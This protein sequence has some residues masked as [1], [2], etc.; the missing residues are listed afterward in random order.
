MQTWTKKHEPRKSGDVEGQ[1]DGVKYLKDF[2]EHYKKHKKRS[3]ILYGPVGCG[4]TVSVY[5]VA[6]ELGLEIIEVNASDF[7][8]E[9]GV[10]STVGSASRQMSLFSKG[11]II[12]VDEIDGLSGTED[13]GGINALAALIEKSAFPIICT[14][15]DPFDKKFANLRKSSEMMQFMPLDYNSIFNILAKICREEK[16]S[17]KDDDLKSLA[18]RIGGDARA[19]VN[20][21]QMIAEA[22]KELRKEDLDELGQREQQDNMINAM[23]KVFKTTDPMIAISAYDNVPEDFDKVFLWI[24]E[25]L[26][27]EYEKPADLERAYDYVSKADVMFRRIRRWQHWRFLVY[28]N[29]Y[30]SA[31]VAVSKDEKYKKFV[32]YGPTTRILK[33]WM[34]NQKYHRRKAIAEKIASKTHS[35][36]KRVITD[37]LPYFQEVFRKNK[38]YGSLIAEELDLS[39]E[40]VE[41][42]RK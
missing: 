38:G 34:A 20:D 11:K 33:L 5:V 10:N 3:L 18:R 14:A 39:E 1:A 37:T 28:V 4:K 35:S 26:P 8:N 22:K 27:K 31:G 23:L 6:K 17:Y 29:A 13:R 21:L 12:L 9:E 36:A 32:Q 7:R 19:A 25:N 24:D 16:I 42:L 30:L 2:V 40:E 15:T 41:W